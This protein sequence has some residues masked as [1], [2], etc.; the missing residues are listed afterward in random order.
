MLDDGLANN[1][2]VSRR[3]LAALHAESFRWALS[4]CAH[5]PAEAEDVMQHAYLL[6]MEGRARFDGRSTLK[7]WLFGV[8]RNVARRRHRRLRLDLALATRLGTRDA[9]AEP[10]TEPDADADATALAVRRAIAGLPGR[11]REVLQLVAYADLTLEQA[12]EVLGVSVGSVR[13][14]YHRAKLALRGALENVHDG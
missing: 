4:L 2:R 10:T 8:V 14:H 1:P 9:D 6:L 13:T 7:T 3:A 12:A 11:Q 5:Q